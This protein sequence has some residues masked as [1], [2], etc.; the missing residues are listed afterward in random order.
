MYGTVYLLVVVPRGFHN[1]RIK[2]LFDVQN[3]NSY[4]RM[5]IF[6]EFHANNQ[7]YIL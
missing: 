1:T 4:Q 2:F 3:N 5:F 6:K 7:N